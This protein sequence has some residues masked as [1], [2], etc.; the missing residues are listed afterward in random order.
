MFDSKF[1]EVKQIDS[2]PYIVDA[3]QM[4]TINANIYNYFGVN[5]K[6]LRNE[7]NEETWNAYYEG[8]VEPFAL[9]LSMALTSMSFSENELAFGSEIMFSANRLQFATVKNKVDVITQ[10]FDRGLI[11]YNEGREI[12]QMPPVENGDE[13]MIRGE[14]VNRKER[15]NVASEN[16]TR[17][18][19][20]DVDADVA[21]RGE[22]D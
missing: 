7:W 20:D 19:G 5:E 22:A 2:K 8:K 3:T 9:Q 6:I 4:Q 11:S 15:D 14:Y 1:A 18:Q 10:L 12:L 16:G 17:I 13:F 21:E